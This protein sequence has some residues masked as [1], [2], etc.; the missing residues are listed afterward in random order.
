MKKFIIPLLFASAFFLSCKTNEPVEKG[1]VSLDVTTISTNYNQTF[2]ITP[3]FSTKG[4]VLDK[5]FRF[6]S[7]ADS[8]A[9]VK[10][11]TGGQGEVTANRVG[12]AVISYNSTDGEYKLI[13]NVSVIP[14]STLLNG[15]FYQK[16]ASATEIQSKIPGY[17]VK[18]DSLTTSTILVYENTLAP[19]LKIKKLIFEMTAG[20]LK[21]TNVI[22]E[23][24]TDV[25]LDAENFIRE[26]YLAT[27]KAKNGITYYNAGV[28][29]VYS[30][31]TF[32]G[33]FVSNTAL[34]SGRDLGLG[35]KFIDNSYLGL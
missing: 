19:T 4:T 7:S 32:T 18:V 27:N 24:T 9:S 34:I 35:V 16:D 12:D 26:R 13:C 17:C 14:R 23:N 29:K 15:I 33:I 6:S 22:L 8:I 30:A 20:K 3:V 11:I 5:T 10:M 28:S 2:K 1:T 31:N 25:Q 21:S